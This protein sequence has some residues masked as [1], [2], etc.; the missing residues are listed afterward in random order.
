MHWSALERFRD[1]G[2]AKLANLR[3]AAASGLDVPPTR[4]AMAVDLVRGERIDRPAGAEF[5]GPLVVRSASPTEDT[6]ASSNAG[7]FLSLV[8]PESSDFG[9]AVRRVVAALPRSADGRPRGAVFVQPF[10]SAPRAG[11]TFF[12]GFYFEETSAGGDNQDLTAGRDRGAVELGH[13]GRDDPRSVWLRA[14]HRVFAGTLDLEWAEPEPG[15]R[16]LLQARPALFAVRRNPTLSLANHKEVFG[17]PPC[18]WL[19]GAILDA[20]KTVLRHVAAVEPAVTTW[21]EDYAVEVAE[22]PWM[23]FSVF[24]RLMD[25]W[26]LPRTQF[27]EGVG[28][29]A[30]GPGDDRFD[31]PRFRRKFITMARMAVYNYLTIARMP[32]GLRALDRSLARA[33]DLAELH[34]ATVEGMDLS[35]RTNIALMQVLSVASRLRRRLGMDGAAR[36]LTGPMME[37]FAELSSLP[38]IHDRWA[39]LD[40]WLADYGHR[41]PLESDLSRPRFRELREA[42]RSDLA[43][44]PESPSR[45]ATRPAARRMSA[46]KRFFFLADEW[47]EWFRDRLMRRWETLRARMLEQAESAVAAGHLARVDDVFYLRGED[48]AADPST[49][50]ARVGERRRRVAQ[51]RGLDLPTTAPRDAIEAAARSSTARLGP[52]PGRWT[53]IGLGSTPVVGRAVRA[54]DVTELLDGRVLPESAIL[55][56]PCL[57]PSWA[58]LFPRF[59]GVVA[60]LGGEMSHAA[61]LLREAGISAVVNAAG[62]H[63]DVDDDRLL[64]LDPARGEI[65]ALE[66]AM[67]GA[68]PT[69]RTAAAALFHK[70]G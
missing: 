49:W 31:M 58:V 19:T 41:G 1:R 33:R 47:R 54:R 10:V 64:R 4:W 24:F 50:R 30:D 68:S 40:A 59:A 27:T 20:G 34:H 57:E 22:R 18:P 48:L 69:A 66:P 70:T 12:D 21:A 63:R 16:V 67:R 15:R 26:G 45:A 43:R 36:V 51:A 25:H 17:D 56:A 23:N 52:S 11:V 35:I 9:G 5:V 39:G 6:V 7:R 42:L 55:V 28:G 65:V 61:I 44:A 8:V 3:L 53:G 38:T 60:E 13:L 46:F 2:I 37:R 62:V 32:A 14:V 29:F